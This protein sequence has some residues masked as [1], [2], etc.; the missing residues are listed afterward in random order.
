MAEQYVIE[1]E[2]QQLLGCKQRHTGLFRRA[3]AFTLVAADAGGYKIL[4]GAFAALGAGKYV[5]QRQVLGGFVFTAILAQIAVAN[6][7]TRSLHRCLAAITAHVYIMTQP[8]HRWDLKNGRRRA[9]NIIPVVF[10]DKD[11]AAK[12]QAHCTRNADGPE[13]FV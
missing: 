8:D 10:F 3:V 11:R 1:A 13:R 2:T 12:P 5:I 6:I 4:R 7:D 9:E